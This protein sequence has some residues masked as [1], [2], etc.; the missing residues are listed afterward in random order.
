[1]NSQWRGWAQKCFHPHALVVGVWGGGCGSACWISGISSM[2]SWVGPVFHGRDT[3]I[4][5]ADVPSNISIARLISGTISFAD[6]C[7]T[8]RK[9]YGWRP[10]SIEQES[11]YQGGRRFPQIAVMLL[12]NHNC[13]WIWG[14]R[15][16]LGKHLLLYIRNI[17]H[18]TWVGPELLGCDWSVTLADMNM[19][20]NIPIDNFSAG[21]SSPHR[22]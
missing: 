15:V 18:V 8:G 1:M 5:V 12:A 11:H 9:W 20:L 13:K 22:A 7:C 21:I 2:Y 10:L 3:G 6:I 19:M 14:A 16:S 4:R 17:F